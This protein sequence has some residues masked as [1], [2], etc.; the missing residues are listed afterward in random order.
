MSC[1]L[2]VGG[3][4]AQSLENLSRLATVYRVLGPLH[5]VSQGRHPFGRH[6]SRGGVGDD[7]SPGGPRAIV[8]NVTNDRGT[9]GR[10]GHAKF[11]NITR[12]QAKILRT[13]GQ[14]RNR[15]TADLPDGGRTG[16]THLVKSVGAADDQSM[17]RAENS[18]G[19]GHRIQL[20]R[21]AEAEEL[22]RRPR[23]VRKWAEAVEDG[24][25]AESAA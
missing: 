9:P 3:T 20:L 15:P 11:P 25:D 18:E 21:P 19:P 14:R 2:N 6:Q 1:S 16:Q 8:E 13:P 24:A 22:V 12:F 5:T 4:S 10:V 7:D 23:G 17:S